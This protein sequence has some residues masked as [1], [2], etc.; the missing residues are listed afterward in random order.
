MAAQ[1]SKRRSRKA[2]GGASAGARGGATASPRPVVSPRREQRG[3]RL[4]EER[5]TTAQASRTLGTVGERPTSPFGGLP[6]SEAAIAIGLIGLIVGVVEHN[7][8][9]MVVCA[10]V[11]GLGVAEVTAREHFSGFR[12]HATLLAAIPAVVVETIIAF[13]F[14]VPSQRILI[15]APVIPVFALCFWLLRRSFESARHAR[16]ARPPVP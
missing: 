14:G 16:V 10:I 5:R 4:A 3:A 7:G 2:R 13:V 12:S 15:L 8:L 1:K 9:A 6:I 11:C